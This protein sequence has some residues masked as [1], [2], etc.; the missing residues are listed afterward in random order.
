ME[1]FLAAVA[2]LLIGAVLVETLT[3]IIGDRFVKLDKVGLSMVMGVIVAFYG[4]FNVLEIVGLNYGWAGNPIMDY[5]GLAIGIVFS[6][7]VLSTGSNGIHDLISKLRS[8]KELAQVKTEAAKV[9]IEIL[10]TPTD[11]ETTSFK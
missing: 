10:N 5:V 1:V 2:G 11:N 6:G 4:R 3:K 7:L 9:E 8:A